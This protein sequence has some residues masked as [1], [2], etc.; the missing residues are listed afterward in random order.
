MATRCVTGTDH[1]VRSGSRAPEPGARENGGMQDRKP[2]DL[3][4]DRYLPEADRESR[5]RAR[6]ALYE[7]VRVLFAIADRLSEEEETGRGCS[8]V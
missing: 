7:Y 6:A 3:L 5:E 8:T 2:G 4:L 1:D